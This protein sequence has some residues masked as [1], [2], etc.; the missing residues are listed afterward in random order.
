MIGTGC[1]ERSWYQAMTDACLIRKQIR[2]GAE[3]RQL[4]LKPKLLRCLRSTFELGV[5]VG[6]SRSLAWL[7]D[8][9]PATAN[10]FDAKNVRAAASM[11]L[12]LRDARMQLTLLFDTPTTMLAV[13]LTREKEEG[14]GGGPGHIRVCLCGLAPGTPEQTTFQYVMIKHHSQIVGRLL[15]VKRPPFALCL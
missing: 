9:I 14:K 2:F 15:A 10:C 5:S 6:G 3:L 13:K 12:K 8:C 11:V 7:E 1:K 4:T